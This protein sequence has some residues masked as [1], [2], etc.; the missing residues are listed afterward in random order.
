MGATPVSHGAALPHVRMKQLERPFL[1]LA[2]VRGGARFEDGPVGAGATSDQPIQA[3]FFLLGPV[4][5]PGRH[6]RIL[7]QIARRVDQDSFMPEWLGAEGDD[8]LK[9]ALF[10]NERLLVM[11]L[12]NDSGNAPLIGLKLRDVSFPDGTLIAMIRRDGKLVVPTGDTVLFDGDRLTVLGRSEGI[13]AVRTR[14]GVVPV[15]TVGDGP[16]VTS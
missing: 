15:S 11:T 12:S 4:D 5:D 2:R 10:R 7:A 1:L 3:V 13:S 8:Q 14:Y 6:L 16:G 9:E